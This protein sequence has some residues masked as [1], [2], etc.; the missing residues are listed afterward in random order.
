MTRPRI[1]VVGGGFAG[2]ECLHRLERRL[3]PAD[4]ELTLV[5]PTDY[6]LY[7]PLLPHV[8]SGILTPQSVA[9]SLRRRL[10]RTGIVP[11]TAEHV[12]PAARTVTVRPPAGEPRTLP[13]DHLVLAAGSTTR[14]FDIPG[15][16]DHAF[17]MKTLAQAAYLRDHV[18][19]QLDLAAAATDETE[20]AARMRFVVVGGGYAG[21][22]TLAALQR[23][24]A[25][26]TGRFP[27]LD[28]HLLAWHLVD[29]APALLP[30]LGDRLGRKALDTLRR[31]GVEVSL[32]TSVRRVAP[33]AVELTD[34]RTLPTRT[35]VWTAGVAA[36]PL[37]AT[38]GT[39]TLRGRLV[40]AADLTVPGADGVLAV[41]DAAAVPDL[42]VGGD[43]VTPPTAQ[44]AQ[45]QG[46]AAADNLVAR[47]RGAAPKPYRH[48]DLGLVVDLGGTEAVAKPL[49]VELSGLPAQAVARGYHLLALPTVTARTR[50]LVNWLLNATTGDDFV[51]TGLQQG[52]PATIPDFEPTGRPARPRPA[53]QP[54][55]GEPVGP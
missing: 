3:A 40:T 21:V 8:A 14:T 48:R 51:R 12:D 34:G 22:E 41:G 38:L 26:A 19:A 55:Q 28:P 52:R 6:Q 27:R 11:G 36:S 39:A 47:L 42:A 15:L 16:T 53:E 4:A 44:H 31:R 24:T 25:A 46:R 20:R 18:I 35:L 13:Y 17:G 23:L 10:R 37:V 1:V 33:D 29:V 50:V 9:V 30:E 2:A 45:R 54:R 49:G 7:L 43:A 32:G 5:S